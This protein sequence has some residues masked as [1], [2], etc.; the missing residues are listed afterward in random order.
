MIFSALPRAQ[1]AGNATALCLGLGVAALALNAPAKALTFSWSYLNNNGAPNQG[2]TVSGT[3]SGL[4]EGANDVSVT[5]IIV[6]VLQAQNVPL[7]SFVIGTNAS[8]AGTIDVLNGNVTAYDFNMAT[9]DGLFVFGAALGAPSEGAGYLQLGVNADVYNGSDNT[10]SPAPS[11]V[12][13]PLP[14]LG[15]AAAFSWSR[16]LRR[17][18]GQVDRQL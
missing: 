16:R 2:G 5:G 11:P 17:R 10:F 14:V 7:T 18:A 9:D 15:T 12:P 8:G 3:I 13:G 1:R 6:D 4:A